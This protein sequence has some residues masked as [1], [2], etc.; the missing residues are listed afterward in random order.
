MAAKKRDLIAGFNDPSPKTAAGEPANLQPSAP[1]GAAQRMTNTGRS[2][3][4][5]FLE[6]DLAIIHARN[7][8]LFANGIKPSSNLIIRAAIRLVAR[9]HTL[10]QQIRELMA[11]DRRGQAFKR[12]SL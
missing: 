6:E 11:E 7:G 10:V 3:S 8:Y 5:R 2:T 4:F 9:D 1:A 12:K